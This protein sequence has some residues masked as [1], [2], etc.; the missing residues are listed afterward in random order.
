[1]AQIKEIEDYLKESKSLV[2]GTVDKDGAPQVRH[3]G[4]YGV[5]GV[6]VYFSTSK[7]TAKVAQIAANPKVAAIFH[8][9][10]QTAPNF[11]NITLYGKAQ[12]LT[13]DEYQ[14]G[15]EIIKARRP[16]A[17]ISPETSNIYRIETEK[18][19]ILDF[20]NG[21]VQVLEAKDIK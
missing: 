19:K 2:L 16:Q 1:M 8:H 17:K 20:A 5:D 14:K 4:G 15:I 6:Q 9:E 3:L 18:V 10:G 12:L 11:K 7:E 13:G 21:P